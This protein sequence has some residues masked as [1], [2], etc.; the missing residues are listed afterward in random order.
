VALCDKAASAAI[1]SLPAVVV[2]T[3]LTVHSPAASAA[4][5]DGQHCPAWWW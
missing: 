3:L 4:T 1:M 5:L 2:D